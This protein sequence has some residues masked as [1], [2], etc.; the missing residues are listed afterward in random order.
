LGQKVLKKINTVEGLHIVICG[1]D[2]IVKRY[3][4]G[5]NRSNKRGNGIE[6]KRRKEE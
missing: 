3:K 5:E 6:R 2:G 1:R 4:L